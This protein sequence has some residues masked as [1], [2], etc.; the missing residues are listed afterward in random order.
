M[1]SP[2]S[3]NA[4]SACKDTELRQSKASWPSTEGV[5][6][7]ISTC[8]GSNKSLF[9]QGSYIPEGEATNAADA[10]LLTSAHGLDVEL[11]EFLA[12]SGFHFGEANERLTKESASNWESSIL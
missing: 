11:V 9:T 5:A 6:N 12:A 10:L 7:H 8:G 2:T 4:K 3:S 1:I